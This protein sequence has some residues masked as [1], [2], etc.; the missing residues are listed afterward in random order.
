ASVGVDVEFTYLPWK[1]AF[2]EARRGEYDFTSFWYAN[3]ERLDAV[4]ASDPVI[5]NRT[6]FFQRNDEEPIEWQ[7]LKDLEKYRLSATIGFTYTEEF[8][9][10]IATRALQATMV[11]TDTQNIKMLMSKRVDLVAT[12]EMSGYY[13]AA[14]LSVDPRKL[15]VLEPELAKVNGYLMATKIYPESIE[16]IEL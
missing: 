8:L 7:T 6:V 2:E 15:R 4:L 11:P 12:D 5:Q 16:L 10:A 14:T 1:R 13:M 3:S 9:D